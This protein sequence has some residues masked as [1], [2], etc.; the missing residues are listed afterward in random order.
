M[1]NN[2]SNQYPASPV[3]IKKLNQNPSGMR[4][5]SDSINTEMSYNGSVNN[6]PN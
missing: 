6:I 1:N 4:M 2:Y 5:H 3:P